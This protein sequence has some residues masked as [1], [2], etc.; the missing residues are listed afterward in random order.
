MEVK[1][2]VGHSAIGRLYDCSIQ[3]FL[4]GYR[5]ATPKVCIP[6]GQ[7]DIKL[8]EILERGSHKRVPTNLKSPLPGIAW[9]VPNAFTVHELGKTPI[10]Y[11]MCGKHHLHYLITSSRNRAYCTYVVVDDRRTELASVRSARIQL[12][13][14]FVKTLEAASIMTY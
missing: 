6:L 8:S 10:N 1:S 5:Y 13:G 9:A 3:R 4:S 12:C 14:D 7:K 11:S 2:A